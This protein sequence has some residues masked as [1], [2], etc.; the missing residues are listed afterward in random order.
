MTVRHCQKWHLCKFSTHLTKT[1]SSGVSQLNLSHHIEIC[2]LLEQ[3]FLKRKR[4]FT[5]YCQEFFVTSCVHDLFCF[6]W[7]H[8]WQSLCYLN[9]QHVHKPVIQ[10]SWQHDVH[11][12]FKRLLIYMKIQ[13]VVTFQTSGLRRLCPLFKQMVWNWWLRENYVVSFLPT[14]RQI[15][16]EDLPCKQMWNVSTFTQVVY[17]SINLRCL[18]FTSV[19][20]LTATSEFYYSSIFSSKFGDSEIEFYW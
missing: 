9:V 12:W 17:L 16:S 10:Q 18:C 15:H 7:W 14:W 20:P 8:K 2:I 6:S 1:P 11:L 5:L 13:Y 3:Q 19:F 4:Y